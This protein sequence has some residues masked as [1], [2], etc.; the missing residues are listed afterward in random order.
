[1]EI[2]KYYG[3]LLASGVMLASSAVSAGDWL[4]N[5]EIV[6]NGVSTFVYQPDAVEGEKNSLML[7]LHSCN[8]SNRD[9]KERGGWEEPADQY[10]MIVAIPRPSSMGGFMGCWDFSQGM[11]TNRNSGHAKELLDLVDAM[12]ND[13]QFN[14]D[15]NQVYISG[16]GNGGAMANVMTCLAP[17]V[18]AG[19]GVSAGLPAGMTQYSQ[20][21]IIVPQEISSACRQLS[22]NSGENYE[23][24]FS[25][26]IY[27]AVHG[28]YDNVIDSEQTRNSVRAME[29]VY[30]QTS[31]T[32]HCWTIAVD[33]YTTG[34][35][36]DY[37]CDGDGNIGDG[38]RIL[39]IVVG[40]LDH[41]WPEGSL[42][43]AGQIS[44]GDLID[45]FSLVDYPETLAGWLTKNNRRVDQDEDGVPDY[46]DNC[47]DV[48][49]P[50]QA[51]MNGDGVGDACTPDTDQD[52]YPDDSDNCPYIPN[53]NQMDTDLDGLGDVCD[54]SPFGQCTDVTTN[55]YFH[56]WQG[57]A[58]YVFGRILAKGSGDDLGFTFSFTTVRSF[59]AKPNYF[60][61]GACEY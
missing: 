17:D 12:V 29:Q 59:E 45:P 9:L 33:G 20:F 25:S 37:Y 11:N 47:P 51:D 44:S 57:R 24:H 50:D 61:L 39:H 43:E 18:F 19:A 7:N 56:I 60:E 58:D 28:S 16:F 42:P 46:I 52:G 22:K 4:S 40:N 41:A 34:A 6:V 26:Q 2:K 14:I 30:A 32:R 3:A 13:P 31:N 8:Q 15:K 23:F 36:F 21:P 10:G 27:N 49:N 35:M 54:E 48:F 38:E 5:S 1:M 55:G 53:P